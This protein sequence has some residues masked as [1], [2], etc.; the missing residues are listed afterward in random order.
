SI[1]NGKIL[2]ITKAG[3]IPL[4]NP[5]QDA[6]SARC[7]AAGHTDAG[8]KCQETF[9]W[10]LRNPYRI[11]FDPNTPGTTTRFFINDVGQ[12]TWEEI[13]EAVAGADYGWNVREGHCATGSPTD[14]GPPPA[15][16]TNPVYDY[17]H[18]SG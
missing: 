12:A 16:M 14:C 5:F 13:D 3:D 10:G 9:A 18:T 8:K 17:A 1:L 4:G 7:N 2:R 15:G 11:S 6:D